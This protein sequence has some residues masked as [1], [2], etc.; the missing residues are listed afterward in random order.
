MQKPTGALLSA[1]TDWIKAAK[2]E[3]SRPQASTLATLLSDYYTTRNA[4]AWS[5]NAKIGNLKNFAEAV[6]YLTEKSITTPE[7]IEEI[8]KRELSES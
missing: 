7:E 4:G 6:N 1:L 3:L 2:A 5:R 8:S